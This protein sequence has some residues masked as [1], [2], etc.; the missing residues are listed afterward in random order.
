M[1]KNKGR[2]FNWHR[3]ADSSKALRN[4]EVDI[5]DKTPGPVK[6]IS[7]DDYLKEK[8]KERLCPREL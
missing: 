4:R 1:Y 5:H 7:P 6:H 2:R 3:G 8:K